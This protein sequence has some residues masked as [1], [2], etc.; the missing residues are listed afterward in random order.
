MVVH[1]SARSENV[2]HHP[3]MH[4]TMYQVIRCVATSMTRTVTRLSACGLG[5]PLAL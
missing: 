3:S 2:V 1:L 4:V 5:P